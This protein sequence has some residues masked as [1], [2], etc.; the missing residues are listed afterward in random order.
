[1]SLRNSRNSKLIKTFAL[2]SFFNFSAQ[3]E[4][5]PNKEQSQQWAHEFTLG[6]E[7][8]KY[9]YE[10]STAKYKNF[11]QDNGIMYGLNGT[12][13]LTYKDKVFLRP[14]ARWA[15]GYTD[16]TSARGS[17]SELHYIP[18][19]IFEPRLLVGIP[20]KTTEQLTLSPYFGVGYRYK[21][22]DCS[23][24]KS[25]DNVGGYK[26]VNK[27]W[28]VPLG[29]RFK[30][31]FS[32]RWFVQGMAEY[33]WFV[34]GR[35]LSYVKERYPSPTVHKQKNGWGARGE[36]LVGH[37]FDKVS[38][39]FGTYMNYWKIGKTK[40]VKYYI[41]DDPHPPLEGTAHEPKNITKEIGIK[42]NFIF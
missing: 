3:A 11:M 36:L 19:L 28:Y 30:Y 22:D 5:L 25:Q 8:C 40:E 6:L 41:P 4:H 17:S 24:M 39:A 34:S 32:N 10:E 12:Y 33:D 14:E 15:Y 1:M 13:Q 35:Q 37:H 31:D 26:R 21:W 29:S 38:I 27:S 2:S 20:L 16:Y 42:L 7:S 18:N 23:D 9:H